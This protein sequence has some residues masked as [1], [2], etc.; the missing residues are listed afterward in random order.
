MTFRVPTEWRIEDLSVG[1]I[2]YCPPNAEVD[3]V[4]MKSTGR[5]QKF[6]VVSIGMIGAGAE[7]R[8]Y[9]GPK[10]AEMPPAASA[11]GDGAGV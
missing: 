9:H 7:L 3:P 10:D 11:Q 6:E 8:P 1:K 2:I 4:T 5:L